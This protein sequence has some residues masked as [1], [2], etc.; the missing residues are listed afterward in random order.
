MKPVVCGG[1]AGAGSSFIRNY[2]L[3]ALIIWNRFWMAL[4]LF[5]WTG[6]LGGADSLPPGEEST[7]MKDGDVARWVYEPKKKVR[8][9]LRRSAWR[10]RDLKEKTTGKKGWKKGEKK[11]TLQPPLILPEA[12]TGFVFWLHKSV[13]KRK[14]FYFLFLNS[15][16]DPI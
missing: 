10:E 12:C 3:K 7:S 14:I 15:L 4:S 9:W 11:D 8:S 1:G 2:C 13:L 5:N 6:L 16:C